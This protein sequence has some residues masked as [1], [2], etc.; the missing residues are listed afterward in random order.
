MKG[1]PNLHFILLEEG[2][3]NVGGWVKSSTL[4]FPSE[5]EMKFAAVNNLITAPLC[6][7][8]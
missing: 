7:C 6:H 3:K 2:K 8:M 1:M 4:F 5:E